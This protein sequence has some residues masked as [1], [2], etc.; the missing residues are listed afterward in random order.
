MEYKERD[1]MKAQNKIKNQICIMIAVIFAVSIWSDNIFAQNP[2]NALD[3][4]GSDDFVNIPDAATLDITDQITIEGWFKPASSSWPYKKLVTIDYTKVTAAQSNFPVLVSVTDTDLLDSD[5]GG[6]VQPDGDD[7]L[8]I[9]TDGT[10]LSHEIEEYDGSTGTLNAWVEIPALSAS[11]DTKFYL[12]YGNASCSSQQDVSGVW[13]NSYAGVWHME[14]NQTGTTIFQDG[15]E[16]AGGAWDDKWDG[17]GVTPWI[18]TDKQFIE[19]GF[20]AEGKNGF[21]T[22]DDIDA[23]GASFI[24]I[25]FWIRKNKIEVDDFNL[26]FYNGTSYDKVARLDTLGADKVWLR[27]NVVVKDVQYLRSDFRI[28]FETSLGRGEDVWVDDVEIIKDGPEIIDSSPNNNTGNK[29]GSVETTGLFGNSQDFDGRDDR[30]DIGDVID[31]PTAIT[32]SAWVKHDNVTNRTER[33]ISLAN[34]FVIRH[35]GNHDVGELDFYIRE[36]ATSTSEHIRLID[37]L[38]NDTWFYVTG[39]W[40]GTEMKLYLDGSERLNLFPSITPDDPAYGFISQSDETMDGNIEEVRISSVARDSSWIATEYNNQNSPGTFLSLGIQVAAGIS[41]YGAYS[42]GTDNTNAYA[43]IND[44]VLS[45]SINAGEWNHISLTYDRT[46]ATVDE[47]KLYINGTL[48]AFGDYDLPIPSNAND[49]L[50]G[51]MAGFLGQMDEVRIWNDVRTELEIRENMH[52]IVSGSEANLVAYWQFNESS[53]AS[54]S[55]SQTGGS[56]TGT[57][58]NMGD[59]DWVSS[60]APFGSGLVNSTASFTSGTV[61]LGTFSLTTTEDF[62]NAIDLT[63]TEILNQPNIIPAIP[64]SLD[65]RYWV[66]DAFGTPGTYTTNLTFTLP[67]GYLVPGEESNMKLFYRSSNSDGSW[68][69]IVTGASGMT[70]TTVTFDN[71]SQLGQFTITGSSGFPMPVELTSFTADVLENGVKLFWE[72]ATELNNYGFQVERAEIAGQWEIIGFVEGHGNSYSPKKYQF[73]DDLSGLKYPS[74]TDSLNYRLKQIDVDG[75][76]EYYVL[77]APVDLRNITSIGDELFPAEFELYQNYPNPFNP[78]SKIKFGLPESGKI[79]L[80]IYNTLG[81][82][83]ATLIDREMSAGY[84]EVEWNAS[85]FTSGIY[86]Y[87][88]TTQDYAAVK[89]MMLLR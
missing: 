73:I 39:T 38:T 41:K 58:N 78:T 14:D 36:G 45:G 80:E 79:L 26:Y 64:D 27:F 59:E 84:H 83:V 40:D 53:G 87:K 35:D 24:T 89:K 19:G 86:L 33:Y 63:A 71:V 25:D 69:E 67:D 13:D 9:G 5:N 30:V 65:D 70:T 43:S 51:D 34:R 88:I 6:S 29:D 22:S 54:A 60:T 50:L 52:T 17:N 11:A 55:D 42:I 46:A 74:R 68:T 44:Q 32:L 23:S 7:I 1:L 56:H 49:L 10:K 81:E 82:R 18:Q 8:F 3:F 37:V 62:D 2:G 77:G 28:R 48:S 75:K 61:A 4:D 47:M 12:Y 76:Y 15:F 66:V 85:G 16:S 72:T 57:L 21:L 31:S 20:S